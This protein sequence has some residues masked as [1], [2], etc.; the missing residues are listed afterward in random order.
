ML[1]LK[2]DEYVGH[3]SAIKVLSREPQ[4][5]YPEHRH[6]FSELVLVSS[7]SG[8]HIVNGHHSVV[9][10]NTIACVSE[11]DYH[12]YSDNHDVTLLNILYNKNQL[13]VNRIAAGI[14]QRLES[15]SSHFLI[16]Q[17][18]FTR[19][20]SIGQQIRI[21][22]LSDNRH[23]HLIVSLL[24][25]QLLLLLDRVDSDK[26]QG[27][28]VMQAIIYLCNNYKEQTLSVN[29]ICD[30]F[31]VSPKNLSNKLVQLTGLST[32]RFIN[33]LRI[34]KAMTLLQEGMTVTEVAYLVGYN[35][36]NYFS[37]KFKAVMG[38]MPSVYLKQYNIHSIFK[39]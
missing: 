30:I 5:D 39:M 25:E 19:L 32:N 3:E 21:E 11:H 20:D 31:E 27:S 23:S 6:D 37:T 26:Y 16:S 2:S 12:Q 4:L 14:I 33:Q 28:P 18:A 10:P 8:I 29:T 7:G 1:F 38:E 9:L 22:Q 15:M 17:E 34:R 13:S 24:F 35:D 36:S